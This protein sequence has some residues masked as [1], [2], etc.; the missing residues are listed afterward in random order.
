MVVG[1]V[2]DLHLFLVY[3]MYFENSRTSLMCSLS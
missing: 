2:L 3:F 1:N